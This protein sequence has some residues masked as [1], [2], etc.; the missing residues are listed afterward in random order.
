M[1][2]KTAEMFGV[3]S[4]WTEVQPISDVAVAEDTVAAGGAAEG[5]TTDCEEQAEIVSRKKHATGRSFLSKL[6]SYCFLE[7]VK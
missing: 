6:L 2:G 5:V 4:A 7:L 1:A 3:G